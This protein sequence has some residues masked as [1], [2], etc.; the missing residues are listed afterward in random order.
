MLQNS[1]E[2][3]SYKTKQK[4]RKNNDFCGFF[5]GIFENNQM[6]NGYTLMTIPSTSV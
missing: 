5:R 4:S 2:K 3:A 1:K 6:K